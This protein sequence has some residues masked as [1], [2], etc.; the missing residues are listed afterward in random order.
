[1]SEANSLAQWILYYLERAIFIQ[2]KTNVY[3]EFV[4]AK[5][6]QKK[7]L[8]IGIDGK[9]ISLAQEMK[10]F[11]RTF[12]EEKDGVEDFLKSLKDSCYS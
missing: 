6:S 8:F 5:D 11:W 7:P 3:G 12:L 4:T 1:M 10:P 9:F 2:Y